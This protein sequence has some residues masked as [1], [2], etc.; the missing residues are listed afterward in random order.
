MPNLQKGAKVHLIEAGEKID[1]AIICYAGNSNSSLTEE[2]KI[3]SLRLF[4]GKKFDFAFIDGGW[5]MLFCDPMT[6]D[7]CYSQNAP[8]YR[9][10]PAS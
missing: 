6:R 5:R 9:I 1:E 7:R 8:V 4:P 2:I 10:E 3:E